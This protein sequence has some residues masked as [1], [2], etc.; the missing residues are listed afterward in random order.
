MLNIPDIRKEWFLEQVVALKE[1]GIP[2]NEIAAKLG[3]KPQYLNSIKN[4]DRGASEK[5]ALK[6][7][8][9]FGINHND[10][11]RRLQTKGKQDA[12][13]PQKKSSPIEV[14]SRGRIPL[15]DASYISRTA[16]KD[17]NIDTFQG[18][19]RE[20]I[21][22]GDLFPGATSAIRHYGDSMPEYPSGC[23]LILKRIVDSRL[24]IWGR[25]YYVETTEIGITK[26]LQD[27]GENYIIGYSSNLETYPDGRLIHEPV[28]IPKDSIHHI[29]LIIGYVTKEFSNEAIPIVRHTM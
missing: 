19:A 11:L 1:K 2:Y 20:W 9:A 27:G 7:C 15:S 23:I 12:T 3:V 5:L 6:L 16:K 4:T 8:N 17:L 22:T 25:N 21:D 14:P 29:H 10:L 26:R 28:K 13:L 18:Q 24:I